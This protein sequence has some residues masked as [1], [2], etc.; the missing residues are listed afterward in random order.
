MFNIFEHR[1]VQVSAEIFGTLGF[2]TSQWWTFVVGRSLGSTGWLPSDPLK[3]KTILS[4]VTLYKTK[5]MFRHEKRERGR[6][7]K[8][9]WR[10]DLEWLKFRNFGP[11]VWQ[12]LVYADDDMCIIDKPA[13]LP[14]IVTTDNRLECVSG[15]LRFSRLYEDIPPEFIP[16]PV[17]DSLPIDYTTEVPSP[18]QSSDVKNNIFSSSHS[19]RIARYPHQFH[20][21]R[22]LVSGQVQITHRMGISSLFVCL[23]VCLLSICICEFLCFSYTLLLIDWL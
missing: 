21:A 4:K 23:F 6:E 11:R 20:R 5:A 8:R 7:I 13:G 10:I 19:Q 15:W 1:S 18:N 22:D 16:E 17:P 9:I 2:Y 3:P 12:W 14:V